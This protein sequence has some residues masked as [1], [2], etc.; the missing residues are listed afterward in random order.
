MTDYTKY[1]AALR[2][3]AN[4]GPDLANGFT[5]HMPMV[6]EALCRM[7]QGDKAETWLEE[8]VD[9]A[10]PQSNYPKKEAIDE[11]WAYLL[12]AEDRFTDWRDHFDQEIAENGWRTVLNIWVARLAPGYMGAATHGI[13]RTAHA[14]RAVQE[15]ESNIRLDELSQGLALWASTYQALP[16]SKA[17]DVKTHPLAEALAA[18]PMVP[19][20]ERQNE[21]AITHAL[22][23]LD[24]RADFAPI[25]HMLD[26]GDDPRETALDLAE[27]L[28]AIYLS[29]AKDPLSSIVFTH[30]VTS[31]AA[32]HGLMA[33]VS[34]DVAA[35]LLRF[36]W[37][38]VAGLYATYGESGAAH[39]E[40]AAETQDQIIHAAV[41]HGDDH[42]IKL[43]EACLGL[44]ALRPNPD[45]LRAPA[46]ARACVPGD[47]R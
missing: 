16:T 17:S 37:Q 4:C 19:E 1:D 23:V 33:L 14:A 11:D 35:T 15:G 6:V 44:Y 3:L 27:A 22:T 18:I 39:A 38:G 12:G 45:F 43:A 47:F 26:L 21:G 42:I 36:A 28:V 34:T 20:D 30:G 41:V 46:L 25:V 7:D 31:M 40:Q 13:L 29:H 2:Q 8:R 9:E 24:D 5:S 32:T 10:L